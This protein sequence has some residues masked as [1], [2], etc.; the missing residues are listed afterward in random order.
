MYQVAT[1]NMKGRRDNK[2]KAEHRVTSP[3]VASGPKCGGTSPA[4]DA[5]MCSGGRLHL[6]GIGSNG[7]HEGD[8]GVVGD[9]TRGSAMAR[10]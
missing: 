4:G 7:I 9:D 5:E 8:V 3:T 2:E 1:T 10:G 6:R